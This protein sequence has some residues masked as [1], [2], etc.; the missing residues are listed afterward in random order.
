MKAAGGKIRHDVVIQD[1]RQERA[2]QKLS[3]GD[4]ALSH[5]IN[6]GADQGLDLVE[7]ARLG[8]QRDREEQGEKKIAFSEFSTGLVQCQGTHL[9]NASNAQQR[10][11]EAVRIPGQGGHDSG[12]IPVTIPK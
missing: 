5:A 1:C 10:A 2:S 12:M 3:I 7:E 11:E 9:G 8:K 6:S 4:M